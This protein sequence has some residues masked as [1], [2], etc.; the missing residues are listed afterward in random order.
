MTEIKEVKQRRC[1]CC[2]K[3]E[4]IPDDI[5]VAYISRVIVAMSTQN[6]VPNVQDGVLIGRCL[7]CK[8]IG[9]KN[10]DMHL[11]SI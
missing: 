4:D 8:A 1:G 10:P 7:A 3:V 5:R 6:L 9:R 2:G 11:V